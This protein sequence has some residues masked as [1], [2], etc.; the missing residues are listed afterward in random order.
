MS[1]AM[2]SSFFWASPWTL[3]LPGLAEHASQGP[4]R[5][6]DGDRLDRAGDDFHQQA[7]IGI[8]QPLALLLDGIG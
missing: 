3:S 8:H 2:T 5:D 7:Q 1:L 6:V 4:L